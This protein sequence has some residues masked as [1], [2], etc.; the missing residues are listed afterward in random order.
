MF[1]FEM[2]LQLVGMVAFILAGVVLLY[3]M[4]Y[5]KAKVGD[6]KLKELW[7]MVCIAVQAAEQIFGPG[8]GVEKKAYAEESL[9]A[10]GIEPSEVLNNLIEAAVYDLT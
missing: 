10:Q 3:L 8:K 7:K 1:D 9:Y 2:V 5:L 6:A 4:P